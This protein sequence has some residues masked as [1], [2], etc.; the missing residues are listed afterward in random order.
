[1]QK[2]TVI[3]AHYDAFTTVPHRGNP[4]GVVLNADAFTVDQMQNIARE[5]GFNE[6]NFALKSD[7]ADVR[8]RYFTPG[9]EMNLCGHGTMATLYALRTHGML[10]DTA[11]DLTIE[12]KAGILPIKMRWVDGQW[13]ITM[14]QAAPQFMP[15]NGSVQELAASMGINEDDLDI[16][17]PIVY[18][19]TGNWTLLVPIRTREAF[20]RMNPRNEEFPAILHEIPTSSVH[21]FCLETADEAADMHA[22]HFSSPHSGTVEDPVTGTASGV[23]GA[24]WMNFMTPDAKEVN[25]TVEQGLEMGRDGKVNVYVVRDEEGMRVEISGTAVFVEEVEIEMVVNNSA[26]SD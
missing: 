4:A 14:Q 2:Q 7:V 18:G 9:G 3:V 5:M 23:M 13:L 25:L 1:M 6:T 19:S 11:E 15:F 22:R 16:N 10:N 8:L 24:Y 20:T 26:S 12:T 17:L 21:P